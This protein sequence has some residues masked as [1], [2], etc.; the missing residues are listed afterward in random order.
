MPI[1]R[2]IVTGVE[3]LVAGLRSWPVT[4][5]ALTES[6]GD[7]GFPI[8]TWVTLGT[9]MMSRQDLA[10]DERFTAGQNSA[11]VDTMWGVP[12]TTELD[13]HLIDVQKARRL[14]HEDRSYDIVLATM[15]GHRQGIEVMTLSGSPVDGVVVAGG[16]LVIGNASVVFPLG[17]SR[18]TSLIGTAYQDA[19]DYIDFEVTSGDY[20]GFAY[21]AEID[22]LTTDAGT[23]ITPKIV[24]AGGSDLVVGTPSTST[25]WV[26]QSLA[27]TP[28]VGTRYR[29]QLLKGDDAA[30]AYG[31]GFVQRTIA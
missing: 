3:T 20:T 15:I 29:L 28:V 1:R 2:G 6:V 11:Q 18:Q 9:L 23:S 21:T 17:G 22:L 5:Q 27:F 24:V 31:I 26:R 14:V 12:Y 8:E 16:S 13:P 4:V 10:G 19:I 7:T 30:N 25:T